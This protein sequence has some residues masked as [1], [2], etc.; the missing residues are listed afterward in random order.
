MSRM[1]QQRTMQTDTPENTAQS[2]Q[3]LERAA[4]DATEGLD[5]AK[6]PRLTARTVRDAA[7]LSCAAWDFVLAESG[8]YVYLPTPTADMSGAIVV[9]VATSGVA[10]VL[11]TTGK[12][13]GGASVMVTSPI[14]TQFICDGSAW[15]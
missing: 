11:P 1:R 14:P 5:R 10:M 3:K 12:L 13:R 6:A 8:C 9:V 15:W 2:M 4:V 7:S